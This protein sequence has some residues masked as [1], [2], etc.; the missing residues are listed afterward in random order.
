MGP[1]ETIGLI[2][3]VCLLI[4]LPWLIFHYITLWKKGGNTLSVE[5]ERLL[6]ELYDLGRK[7]DER[8]GTIERIMTAENP[9]WRHL[10]ADPAST[11]IERP[12][13]SERNPIQ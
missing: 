13:Y 8:V 6:D 5:D 9:G 12:I 11:G 7:L 10:T 2:A 3:V 1:G 4:G